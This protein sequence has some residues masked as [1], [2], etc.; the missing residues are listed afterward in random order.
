MGILPFFAQHYNRR[1]DYES[2]NLGIIPGI[3]DDGDGS[4]CC[5]HGIGKH[6]RA[7][8]P[9]TVEYDPRVEFL[10]QADRLAGG[11]TTA[12]FN[13]NYAIKGYNTKGDFTGTTVALDTMTSS[14]GGQ[15]TKFQTSGKTA[16]SDGS[17]ATFN[18]NNQ[19]LGS[20]ALR[21]ECGTSV[22]QQPLVIFTAPCDGIYDVTAP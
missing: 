15:Q 16:N 12:V 21:I 18:F 6:L 1:K 4:V 22:N 3:A 20:T 14:N 17:V 5:P 2:K 7:R 8:L 11:E 10:A 9:T 19:G 13:G